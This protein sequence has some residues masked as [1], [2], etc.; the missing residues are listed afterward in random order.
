M[1]SCRGRLRN[2]WSIQ[3]LLSRICGKTAGRAGIAGL[4][5]RIDGGAGK[6]RAKGGGK[7]IGIGRGR[8]RVRSE[9]FWGMEILQ[10]FGLDL[11]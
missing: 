2:E 6:E 5:A 8:G 10:I 7:G 11:R 4:R 1:S 9:R 3:R